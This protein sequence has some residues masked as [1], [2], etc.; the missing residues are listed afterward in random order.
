MAHFFTFLVLTCVF[1]TSLN[2]QD[3]VL[4][5]FAVELFVSVQYITVGFE[6]RLTHKFVK[7]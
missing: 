4:L 2:K 7:F 6:V 3:A 1:T 5:T